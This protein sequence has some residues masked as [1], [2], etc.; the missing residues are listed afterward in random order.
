MPVGNDVQAHEAFRQSVESQYGT[1]QNAEDLIR[2]HQATIDPSLRR[3]GLSQIDGKATEKL[4]EEGLDKVGKRFK[5][6]P[7]DAELVDFAVRGNALVGVF[8]DANGTY[9]KAVT[10][11][12]DRYTEAQEA[13]DQALL[14][15]RARADQR[16]AEETARLNAEVEERVAE[17]R[18][19]AEAKVSSELAKIREQAEKD[20]EKAHSQGSSGGGSGSG[21][22]SRSSRRSSPARKGSSGVPGQKAGTSGGSA[23]RAAGAGEADSTGLSNSAEGAEN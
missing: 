8:L 18:A 22:G 12:N 10:G 4:R 21:S 5:D 11:A 19:E 20:V 16:V 3:A 1:Y 13:G 7:R 17:A 23:A 6:A 2:S 9:H 14:R 15:A